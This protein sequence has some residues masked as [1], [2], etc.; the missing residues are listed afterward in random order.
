MKIKVENKT[1]IRDREAVICLTSD[2]VRIPSVYRENTPDGNETKVAIPVKA[3]SYR[4][5]IGH[6]E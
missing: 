1:Y 2:L 6:S 5:Y 3:F 4:L